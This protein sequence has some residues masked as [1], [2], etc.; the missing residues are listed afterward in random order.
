[1]KRRW[2]SSAGQ[3]ACALDLSTPQDA[4]PPWAAWASHCGMQGGMLGPLCLCRLAPGDRA[5]LGLSSAC[6]RP[7]RC[8]PDNSRP[9]VASQIALVALS[10]PGRFMGSEVR[11]RKHK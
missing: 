7:A 11:P 4:A 5:R 2:L 10:L 8:P 3:G 6:Q 1:M 9:R